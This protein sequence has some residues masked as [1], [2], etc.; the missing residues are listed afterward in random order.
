MWRR[1][2]ILQNFL[3]VFINDLWETWKIRILKKLKKQKTKQNKKNAGDIIVLHKCTKSHNHMKY[4]QFLRYRVRQN[5]FVI[6]GHFFAFLLS[7]LPLTNQKT[8]I[9]KKWKKIS[10]DVIIHVITVTFYF[11]LL[12]ALLPL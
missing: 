9:L 5:F 1:W 11:G 4:I 8:Q 3:L 6:C 12:F 10:R 7:T 2:V